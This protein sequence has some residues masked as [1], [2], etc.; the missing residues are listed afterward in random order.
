MDF[1]SKRSHPD[2]GDGAPSKRNS[3]NICVSLLVSHE[4]AGAV[5]GPKGANLTG[6]REQ[7]GCRCVVE[8]TPTHE[9]E[10]V[11]SVSATGTEAMAAGVNS[12]VDSLLN[13]KNPPSGLS[14]LV[15][16]P[17]VGALIGKAGAMVKAIRSQSGADVKVDHLARVL[18]AFA[19]CDVTSLN[20]ESLRSAA[21][22]ITGLLF[23]HYSRDD[24]PEMPDPR[25]LLQHQHHTTRG[26]PPSSNQHQ[27]LMSPQQHQQQQQQQQQQQIAAAQAAAAQVSAAMGYHHLHQ[28]H[29]QQQQQAMPVHYGHHHHH[30]AAQQQHGYQQTMATDYGNSGLHHSPHHHSPPHPSDRMH[31]MMQPHHLGMTGHGMAGMT[32]PHASSAQSQWV[33]VEM[34]LPKA[35]LGN[36]IG[37]GGKYFNAVRQ[38]YGVELKVQDSSQADSS[39]GARQDPS[40]S[41]QGLVYAPTGEPAAVLVASGRNREQV[42]LAC[43]ACATN[44]LVGAYASN[45]AVAAQPA[46]Q[47]APSDGDGSVNVHTLSVDA[48]SVP[49]LIGK[50]GARINLFR[51]VSKCKILVEQQKTAAQNVAAEAATAHAESG[52][53]GGQTGGQG[54]GVATV[55]IEGRGREIVGARMLIQAKEMVG[56]S[57]SGGEGGHNRFSAL[58]AG[59]QHAGS[60]VATSSTSISTST[61]SHLELLLPKRL[62]GHVIGK[63]G[64]GINSVRQATGCDIQVLKDAGQGQPKEQE[65]GG[66][67]GLQLQL[68][69]RECQALWAGKAS[70]QSSSGSQ[71]EEEEEDGEGEEEGS[72]EEVALLRLSGGN[73]AA[74]WVAAGHLVSML[75]AGKPGPHEPDGHQCALRLSVPS[76]SVGHVIGKQGSRINLI[77]QASTAKV[78]V[79]QSTNE[80]GFGVISVE[81]SVRAVLAAR[82]LLQGREV[83]DGVAQSSGVVPLSPI[84]SHH[85]HAQQHA[86][87]Q[88]QQ[89]QQQ[90]QL[91][92]HQQREHPREPPP[93]NQQPQHDG[94]SSNAFAN[95]GSQN[96]GNVLTDR[97]T[98]RVMHPPGGASSFSLG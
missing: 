43:A 65:Q 86:S 88:Q 6:I 2:G 16:L 59:E 83:K 61:S 29:L 97:R 60:G 87:R 41:F 15:G 37:K 93:L 76:D 72:L 58:A 64:K 36:V 27:Q 95:G 31:G 4:H 23:E 68:S 14:F 89:Q 81:G 19:R 54:S 7:T 74:L 1:N 24:T 50:Q 55:T 13:S 98:T 52:Q 32:G 79:E 49:K 71:E 35:Y 91:R 40:D 9:N 8:S 75:L 48:A 26:A 25:A 62:L 67:G 96:T 3:T 66:S 21:R 94:R 85:H 38:A 56:S 51:Q 28:G 80:S 33:T 77:R 53:T 39:Q 90:Q 12:V 20:P 57:S 92:D 34:V 73:S 78:Q 44:L 69:Q 17:T 18:S 63:G 47:A 42:W 22:Q 70:R 10:R 46:S 11:V 84:A 82:V 45:N 5:I 30:Q